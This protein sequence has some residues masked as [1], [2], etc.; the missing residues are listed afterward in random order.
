MPYH[1]L[2]CPPVLRHYSCGN[3][4]PHK[5]AIRALLTRHYSVLLSF[6]EFMDPILALHQKFRIQGLSPY[7]LL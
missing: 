7:D 2:S 5:C 3:T 1:C 4:E 6:P